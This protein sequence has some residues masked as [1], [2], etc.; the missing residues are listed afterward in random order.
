M[1]KRKV[2]QWNSRLGTFFL[3]T[4]TSLKCS[5]KRLHFSSFMFQG[6]Y[7]PGKGGLTADIH[8]QHIS[9]QN[10]SERQRRNFWF[11]FHYMRSFTVE[12]LS[13]TET[14]KN[15]HRLPA[16]TSTESSS[17][18]GADE[19]AILGERERA[20][21]LLVQEVKLHH[22]GM[23]WAEFQTRW[24]SVDLMWEPVWG[25]RREITRSL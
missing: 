16:I 11:C 8:E 2:S 10:F 23:F 21:R 6:D 24:E 13:A 4:S 12:K 18:P 7:A 3:F 15:N 14:P 19:D 20:S 22:D 1:R 17:I 9:L 25:R 5:Y